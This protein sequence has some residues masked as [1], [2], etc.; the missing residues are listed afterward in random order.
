MPSEDRPANTVCSVKSIHDDLGAKMKSYCGK[1]Q[2]FVLDYAIEWEKIVRTRID[3]GIRKAAE[4]KRDLDHYQKKVEALRQSTNA[5]MVKGKSVGSSQAEKLQRNE[6]KFLQAKQNYNRISTDLVILM[7][8]VTERSWRDLHPLLIKVAQFDMTLSSDEAKALASLERV[9]S[10]LKQIASEKGISPQ[11]RLKDLGSLKPELISTRPGG[12]AGLQIEYNGSP[13]SAPILS[14]GAFGETALQPGSVGPQGLGGFPVAISPLS[15]GVPRDSS[16]TS[17][18]SQ[19]IPSMNQLAITTSQPPAYEDP[20]SSYMPPTIPLAGG[21]YPPPPTA[22]STQRTTSFDD[23]ASA[24]SGYS[25]YSGYSA[26]PP[27]SAPPPPPPGPP[28]AGSSYGLPPMAPTSSFTNSITMDP[29][30]SNSMNNNTAGAFASSPWS[31]NTPTNTN[32]FSQP[33]QNQFL[34]PNPNPLAMYGNPP[35]LQQP[36]QNQYNPPVPPQPNQGYNPFG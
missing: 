23:C 11:P 9:V 15:G 32:P 24:Y 30:G 17:N 35:P 27:M 6:E 28:M 3:N 1:Y 2:Q 34:N 13:T 29:Y 4:T 19:P 5:S 33:G 36:P 31:G 18:H 10:V 12:V 20:Y 22:R 7:E 21:A 16:F 14:G 26:P 8:E 25:G